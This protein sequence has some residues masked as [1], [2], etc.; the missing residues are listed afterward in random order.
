MGIIDLSLNARYV[1]TRCNKYTSVPF[2]YRYSLSITRHAFSKV[3]YS[4]REQLNNQFSVKMDANIVVLRYRIDLSPLIA[5]ILFYTAT[6]ISVFLVYFAC[7][8]QFS[9]AMLS[10][11]RFRLFHA[12]MP[13]KRSALELKLQ[14]L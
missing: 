11:G 14:T 1:Y 13:S 5:R 9:L 10:S 3:K 12:S 4:T 2:D 7:S 8:S 6:K